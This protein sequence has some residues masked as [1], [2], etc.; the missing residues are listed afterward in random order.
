[1]LKLTVVYITDIIDMSGI[2]TSSLIG[3]L[4]EIFTQELLSVL[5]IIRQHFLNQLLIVDANLIF[6]ILEIIAASG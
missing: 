6:M 2:T 3:C 4:K 5:F 1:M